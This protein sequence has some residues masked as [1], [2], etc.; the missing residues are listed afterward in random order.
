MGITL[1]V[2]G[3][4]YGAFAGGAFY[5]MAGLSAAALLL[6]LAVM[7]GGRTPVC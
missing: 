1:I 2:A 4:L 3:E 5:G 6:A 7:R